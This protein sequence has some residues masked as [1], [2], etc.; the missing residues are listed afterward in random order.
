MRLRKAA[1]RLSGLFGQF[2]APQ[3]AVAAGAVESADDADIMHRVADLRRL[4]PAAMEA[5]KSWSDAGA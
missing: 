4:G 5:L 1:H 3:A 2:G